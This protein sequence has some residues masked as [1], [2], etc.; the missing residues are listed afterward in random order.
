[1]GPLFVG[2]EHEIKLGYGEQG[3]GSV[4]TISS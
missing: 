3:H 1:M 4:G 2:W